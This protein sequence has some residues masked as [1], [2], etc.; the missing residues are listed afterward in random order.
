MSTKTRQLAPARLDPAQLVRWEDSRGNA[1]AVTLKEA[2]LQFCPQATDS[3]VLF[4]LRQCA[5]IR[6]NPYL[7]ELHLV[8][9]DNSAPAVPVL[10]IDL[11]TERAHDHPRYRGYRTGLIDNDGKATTKVAVVAQGDAEKQAAF[12]GGAWCD[13]YMAG[14]PHP[15][16]V[17]VALKSYIKRTRDGRITRFWAD[18]MPDMIEKVSIMQGLRR[19]GVAKGYIPEELGGRSEELPQEALE[20]AQGPS[21]DA[22]DAEFTE[23]GEQGAG[24]EETQTEAPSEA[25][26]EGSEQEQADGATER[27]TGQQKAAESLASVWEDEGEPPQEAA[28]PSVVGELSDAR[29]REELVAQLK[30]VTGDDT[31]AVAAWLAKLHGRD[32]RRIGDL[33]RANREN[34]VEKLRTMRD[35]E[36]KGFGRKADPATP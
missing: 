15:I 7:R 25:Q 30:R 23:A 2:R 31:D 26:D 22:S 24:A 19:A 1:L 36:L 3:E 29:L 16:H 33:S 13:V 11:A 17:E 9:Y 20:M 12:L 35:G 27:E 10:G 8:K 28:E 34:C 32:T 18:L 5:A 14:L 4:F 21:E 6:A